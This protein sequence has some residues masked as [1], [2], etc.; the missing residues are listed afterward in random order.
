[1]LNASV[2]CSMDRN[3][4]LWDEVVLTAPVLTLK[5]KSSTSSSYSVDSS[6]NSP[7]QL[8]SYFFSDTVACNGIREDANL[9]LLF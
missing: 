5:V 4:F 9:S 2:R 6:L 8:L 7:D 1:M 3:F